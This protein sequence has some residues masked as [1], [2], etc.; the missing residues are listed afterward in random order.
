VTRRRAIVSW[1]SGKDSAYAF[2]AARG[3]GE[4]ELVGALTTITAAY[5]RVSM[6]GVRES[7]LDARV[8]ALG[9]PCRKIRIPAPCPN[10]VYER[11]MAAALR[12]LQADGV[13]DHNAG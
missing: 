5:E 11:E 10:E 4:L 9:L 1:S 3:A 7:V 12:E 8:D 6:H 2:H 13:T